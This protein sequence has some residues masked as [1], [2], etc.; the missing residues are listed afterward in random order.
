MIQG[1]LIVAVLAI[2]LFTCRLIALEAERG[3]HL[4]V[5]EEYGFSLHYPD[6]FSPMSATDPPLTAIEDVIAGFRLVEARYYDGTNLDEAA[7]IVAVRKGVPSLS[8]CLNL[9][10]AGLPSRRTWQRRAIDGTV[11]YR[12]EFRDAGAGNFYK[13]TGYRT[14]HRGACYT[15]ALFIHWSDIGAFTPGAVSPFAEGA[16]LRELERVLQA[17][18]FLR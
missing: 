5:N 10:I 8:R 16:V 18:R 3:E 7:V 4:Y 11:F 9:G 1:L 12:Q 6:G 17:F 2:G 13:L 15:L 14:F